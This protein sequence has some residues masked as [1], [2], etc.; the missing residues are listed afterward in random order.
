M[1]GLDLTS[2]DKALKDHY[3]P[4]KVQNMVYKDNPLLAMLPKMKEF[5]GRQLPIP[6]IIGDPQGR[7]RSFTRAQTRA[8]QTSARVVSFN[9]TR[10]HD[11]GI[12]TIDNETLEASKK[13]IDAFLEAKT[14]EIDGLIN[15]LT[16]SL[17]IA[18]YHG[19]YGDIGVIA[20]AG[21][22]T[23][24]ITLATTS[25]VTNFEVGQELDLSA[26]VATDTL[27]AYGSSGNGLIVTNVNRS[28]GVIT[29]GYNVTDATNGIP[30]A[31]AG[32]YIFVR[33][34]REDSATASRL[35]VA[36]L[37]AWNPY[38]TP[39][40]T[41]FFGVDRSVDPTRL[42][43]T[44]FDG[45]TAPIEEALVDALVLNA[46]EGGSVDHFFMPYAQYGNL[47]KSLGSKVQYVDLKVGEVGFRGI[48]INGPKRTV[49]CVPD[50]NCPGNRIH[51]VDM[52]AVKLCSLGE[53]V[54]V[55]NSDGLQF[56]RQASADGVEI[57]YG[58]YANLGCWSPKDLISVNVTAA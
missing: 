21:I 40:S 36:G 35:K 47:E 29:F 50:Q 31:A 48:S 24:T 17:A 12:S 51:G 30:T 41:T 9:L 33:G 2:F 52:A 25:D 55:L 34:D 8:G 32:D 18:L 19:G 13:D 16:R 5:G 45:S 23:T 49:T 42:A 11:Y 3:T 39:T 4:Y 58:Y 43:G 20:T 46:R 10:V 15:S 22:S 57:R 28:T 26:S 27:R 38:T 54:R 44:R 14:T 7:S 6:V 53:V 37:G 56:L 1:A